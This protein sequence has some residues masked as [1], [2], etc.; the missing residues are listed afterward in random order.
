MLLSITKEQR[1]L[2]CIL[3]EQ[4]KE[5]LKLRLHFG[6]LAL[7]SG[8]LW[9]FEHSLLSSQESILSALAMVLVPSC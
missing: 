4:A 5:K 9:N 3:Y 2:T 8:N 7:S 6:T 1:A